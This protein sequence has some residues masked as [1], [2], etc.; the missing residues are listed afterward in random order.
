MKWEVLDLEECRL[1]IFEKRNSALLG[2]WLRSF[3]LED[4]FLWPIVSLTSFLC[5]LNGDEQRIF[6][7]ADEEDD[8]L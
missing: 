1:V 3:P 4:E 8:N 6:N 7:E 2:K 5:Y